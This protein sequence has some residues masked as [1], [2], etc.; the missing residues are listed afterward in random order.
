[1]ILQH[2]LSLCQKKPFI[3]TYILQQKLHSN[4]IL[5]TNIFLNRISFCQYRTKKKNK[6]IDT[7]NCIPDWLIIGL[8]ECCNHPFIM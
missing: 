5:F 8:T 7:H 3:Y 2:A 4:F 6:M 1:M